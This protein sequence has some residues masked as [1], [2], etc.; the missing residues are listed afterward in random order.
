MSARCIFHQYLS[1]V[2]NTAHQGQFKIRWCFHTAFCLASQ[3]VLKMKQFILANHEPTKK[4]RRAM[5]GHLPQ[6]KQCD[7]L[8]YKNCI[9]HICPR[10]IFFSMSMVRVPKNP[11]TKRCACEFQRKHN[12]IWSREIH[13]IVI[14]HTFI[15]SPHI[16]NIIPR[17]FIYSA[18]GSSVGFIVT[19]L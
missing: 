15:R 10:F 14:S 13:V 7:L 9:I 17:M 3:P 4:R 1:R 19:G 5:K 2:E 6:H 12:D 11:S 16:L 8:F 18:V